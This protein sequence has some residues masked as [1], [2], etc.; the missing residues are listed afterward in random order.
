MKVHGRRTLLN[1]PGFSSTAA[2]VAEVEDTAG[3]KEGCDRDGE[4]VSH[5]AFAE[6]AAT[7]VISNC[8][9]SIDFETDWHTPEGRDN[10]LRKIDTMIETLAEFR[11]GVVIEQARY[12]ERM[13]KAET[14]A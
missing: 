3:W 4:P 5:R 11:E 1:G 10:T 7:L 14:K 6:P 12:V 8:N 13:K 9:R 2:I